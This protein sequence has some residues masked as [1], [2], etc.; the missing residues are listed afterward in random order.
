MAALDNT[1][2]T[3]TLCAAG[4][5]NPASSMSCPT[6]KKLGVQPL[7]Q[8]CGQACFE[9]FWPTHK[10]HIYIYIFLFFILFFYQ[11]F[12]SKRIELFFSLVNIRLFT[13]S[14]KRSKPY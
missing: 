9:A 3:V 5:G 1:S 8:F 11:L 4:C 2:A 6:C 10:V 7:A 13:K 14:G 12:L